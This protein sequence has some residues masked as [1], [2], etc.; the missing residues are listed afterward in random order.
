MLN[1]YGLPSVDPTPGFTLTLWTDE[2]QSTTGAVQRVLVSFAYPREWVD[3]SPTKTGGS[4][5]AA[6][7][8]NGDGCRVV[9]RPAP[10][11][12]GLTDDFIALAALP[13]D[14]QRSAPEYKLVRR[15]VSEK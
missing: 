10:T 9:V 15:K 11:A 5:G 7:Y 13:G 12:G 4:V 14:S 6:D 8:K 1:G 2:R 3:S